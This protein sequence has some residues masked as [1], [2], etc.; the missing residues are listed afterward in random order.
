MGLWHDIERYP[1]AFQNGTCGNAFYTLTDE[2]VD[3]FNTQVINQAL[4]TINGFATVTSTD[5]SAKLNVTFPIVGTPL[6]SKYVLY[7]F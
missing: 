5:G 2:G 6:T 3:V 4:D 1:T 7:T